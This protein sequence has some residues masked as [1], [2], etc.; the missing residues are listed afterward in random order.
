MVGLT[1]AVLLTLI[2]LK[3]G[4]AGLYRFR[5]WGRAPSLW[6]TV[7]SVATAAFSGPILESGWEEGWP[8]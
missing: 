2:A 1:G 6:V 7:I 5:T 4:I 8:R 3:V